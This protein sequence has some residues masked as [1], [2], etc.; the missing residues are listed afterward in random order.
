MFAAPELS[1]CG[2]PVRADALPLFPYNHFDQA[3]PF[4]AELYTQETVMKTV[5]WLS[6]AV[7]LVAFANLAVADDKKGIDKDK[8][9]GKWEPTKKAGHLIEMTK[10]G[11]LLITQTAADGKS[12]TFEGTWA[13][14]DGKLKVKFKLPDGN[15]RELSLTV[16]SVTDEKLVTIDGEKK[17]ELRKVT[18]K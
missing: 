12:A 14:T 9:V 15:E 8:L 7:V 1:R 11:K 6:V 5:R 4:R 3:E 17:E 16:E 13:Y 10:D 18:K 2:H